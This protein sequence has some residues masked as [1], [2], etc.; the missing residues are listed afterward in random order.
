MNQSTATDAADEVRA[1]ELLGHPFFVATLFQPERSA[2]RGIEHPL[3]TAFLRSASESAA[4]AALGRVVAKDAAL[5][6]EL[7]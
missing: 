6:V 5:E 2:L 7:D 4:G 3:V 1:V